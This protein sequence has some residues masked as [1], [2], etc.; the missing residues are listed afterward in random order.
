MEKC[1]R[2]GA[3]LTSGDTD[4]LCSKRRSESQ[5]PTGGLMG[6]ICPVCGRG[7]SPY[8][9]F[10]PCMGWPEY[11]VTCDIGSITLTYRQQP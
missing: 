4:G 1:T 9:S 5:L 7:N 11:K 6:W 10:C 8:T 2:C 3:E